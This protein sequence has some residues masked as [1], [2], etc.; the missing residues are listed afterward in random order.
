M[1]RVSFIMALFVSCFLM[2]QAQTEE[3]LT[4][5]NFKATE[6][7]DKN[8]TYNFLKKEWVDDKTGSVESALIRITFENFS[9]EEARNIQYRTPAH[10]SINKRVF[11]EEDDEQRFWI[12]IDPNV[13]GYIEA[14]LPGVGKSNQYVLS[15]LKPKGIYDI[16]LANSKSIPIKIDITTASQE[17][18]MVLLDGVRVDAT[19][20]IPSVKYGTHKLE[21]MR[22]GA[23]IYS[24]SINVNDT[25]HTFDIDLRKSKRIKIS[26]RP[27]GAMISVDG[28]R[29]GQAPIEY[30][31]KYGSYHIE[32][33]INEEQRDDRSIT[34]D[35]YI[36][37]EIVMEPEKRKT[38]TLVAT[39]GGSNVESTLFVN[40]DTVGSRASSFIVSF[41]IGS[42]QE[43][44]MRS[45]NGEKKRKIKIT[46][47]MDTK[48]EFKMA[49]YHTHTMPWNR[50]YVGAPVG[51]SFAYVQKQYVTKSGNQ[52]LI[53]ENGVWDSGENK[54]LSGG[55]FGIHFQP[56]FH[57]GLGLYTGIFY[58]FYYSKDSEGDRNEYQEHDLYAPAHLLFR[59]PL[60]EKGCFFI[61][62]G[63][64]ANYIVAA[65]VG[66]TDVTEYLGK[67]GIFKKFNWQIEGGLG[68][69]VRAI[70]IH[71]QYSFG[72]T[73]HEFYTG[74]DY[75]T[76]MHKLTGTLSFVF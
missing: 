63:V 62:G 31:F 1:I 59:L 6:I 69:R 23:S 52:T 46:E 66:D 8:V 26:S 33:Y 50:D 40:G 5:K 9:M 29:I 7:S 64:G 18:L 71:A 36:N 54:W 72:M 17:N 32:A 47:D 35:D 53:K 22:D 58:E 30:E 55:Q 68:F 15:K 51:L 24:T 48:I 43:I 60:A 4:F 10:M 61:H 49:G 75:V 34:V 44:I 3:V 28:K 19:Q 45:Y 38:V 56:C 73:D 25:R 70:A 65:K 37:D 13:E 11:R 74:G 39:H 21:V 14:F 20:D 16:V 67:D 41:P 57:F 27:K 42:T 12:W 76:K 2:A